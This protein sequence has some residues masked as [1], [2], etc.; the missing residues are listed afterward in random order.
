MPT[1]GVALNATPTVLNRQNV[2][3]QYKK[4]YNGYRFG[5]IE[6]IYNSWSILNFV[7]SKNK[8]FKSFWSNSS[9][10]DLIKE[11]IFERD[12]KY[13]KKNFEILLKGGQIIKRINEDIVFP[14]L[15]KKTKELLWSL[16]LFTGYLKATPLPEQTNTN[17]ELKSIKNRQKN[18]SKENF[19][20]RVNAAITKAEKQI[21][22]KKYDKELKD[23][24]VK[25]IIKL[26]IVFVG[27]KPYVKTIL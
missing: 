3:N 25:N 1:V 22:I 7:A 2:T 27:K 9:S 18:E 20:K 15:T 14:D 17:V 24:K 23:S 16:L 19:Q 21:E 26:A 5:N 13:I 10:N 12:Y 8:R 6:N 11:R 4:W